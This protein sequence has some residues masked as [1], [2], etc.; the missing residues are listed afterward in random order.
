MPIGR[1][2]RRIAKDVELSTPPASQIFAEHAALP[3]ARIV[4]RNRLGVFPRPAQR[5]I[6]GGVGVGNLPQMA[7]DRSERARHQAV[8]Q[9][10][11]RNLSA[12]RRF[13]RLPNELI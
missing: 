2:S 11:S 1:A 7:G 6:I 3:D 12:R 13:A 8:V 9:A 5:P 10:R 4:D